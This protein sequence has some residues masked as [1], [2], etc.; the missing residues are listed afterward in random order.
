MGK[1]NKSRTKLLP[2]DSLLPAPATNPFTSYQHDTF[3][4]KLRH[5]LD[6]TGGYCTELDFNSEDLAKLQ[7]SSNFPT[8]TTAPEQIVP[9]QEETKTVSQPFKKGDH[10][11]NGEDYTVYEYDVAMHLA[12]HF[13]TGIYQGIPYIR[14]DGVDTALTSS[15]IGPLMIES[16]PT[17]KMRKVSAANFKH[18]QSWL[19]SFLATQER[20]LQR[21]PTLV[22]F[23]NGCFDLRNGRQVPESKL[24]NKFFPVRINAS[25][26][27]NQEPN[28]PVFDK[29]LDECSGG[30]PAIRQLML[31]FLG[32]MLAP[33]EPDSIILLADTAGSGKSVLG[34]LARELLGVEKTCAIALANFGKA[35]EVSQIF[36]KVG[37]FCLDISS[38]VLSDATV[39]TSKRLTGG[40]DPETI[41]AKY[42]QPFTYQN[43]AKLVFS[44]NEGGIRLKNPDSG[45]ERRLVIVPFLHAVPRNMMDKRLP[46]KLRAE[47]SGIVWHAMQA[48]QQLHQRNYVFTYCREGE[49][50]KRKY[51]G[52]ADASVQDFIDTCCT[53]TPE[54]QEWT[55]DMYNAYLAYCRE[56]GEYPVGRKHFSQM[57]YSIPGVHAHKFQKDKTQLQGARGISLKPL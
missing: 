16:M 10:S 43:L 19:R 21:D 49:L 11:W 50:L 46:E 2:Y 57:I 37:N 6:S 41:N 35:F 44:C 14:R 7:T 17:R 54:E 38:A 56:S 34:N 55:S 53:L 23:E 27:P 42:E 40:T 51:M 1:K 31:E 30:D 47:Y 36:G 13:S 3:Q 12:N 4:K 15:M 29:F 8:W 25:Y 48:L 33:C 52:V 39:A 20:T 5:E 22:L 45:F 32:Y 28:T 26:S 9:A 18:I 24:K